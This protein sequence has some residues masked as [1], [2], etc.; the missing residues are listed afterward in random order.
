MRVKIVLAG[1]LVATALL[2]VGG[3]SAY[4]DSNTTNNKTTVKPAAAPIA[5][6]VVKE[7]DTLTQI[8]T[9]NGTT[10]V[11]LYDA[12][13]K[14]EDPDLILPADIIRI[15][16]ADEQLASRPLPANAPP[17][18]VAPASTAPAVTRSAAAVTAPSPTAAVTYNGGDVWSSL[19]Q[20]E[21]GGNWAINTGNG[22]YGGLQFTLSSW[23]SVGGSG[24]PSEA[25]PSEQ[26]TRG[27]MLQA[28]SGWGAW[29]ACSARLGLR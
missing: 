4:A 7:G 14:I 18:A 12:N 28:R 23:A 24:L 19:A 5:Q 21:A 11:R 15:P 6:V 17:Q 8:A 22:Y 1:A 9:D 27:Q 13:T 25:S 16:A 20:C 29:P 2:G 26:I 10:Y 3:S